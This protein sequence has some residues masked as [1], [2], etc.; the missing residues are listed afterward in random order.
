VL[1]LIASKNWP[2]HQLDVSN[3]FL[4]GDIVE[5]VFC[6]QPTGFEDPQRPDDMCLLT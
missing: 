6:Q 2:A 4:H 1:T 3:A 5:R